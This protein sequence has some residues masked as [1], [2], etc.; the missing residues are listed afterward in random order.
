[1]TLHDALP[2]SPESPDTYDPSDPPLV[3]SPV[4]TDHHPTPTHCGVSLRALYGWLLPSLLPMLAAGT[5][6]LGWRAPAA[7]AT[8]VVSTLVAVSLWRLVGQRGRSLHYTHA[9]LLAGLLA[10]LMPAELF[11]ASNPWYSVG[12]GAAWPLL[13]AAGFTLAFFYWLLGGVGSRL[14]PVA[15]SALALLIL[16][17]TQLSPTNVLVRPHL[18]TGNLLSA[19]ASPHESSADPHLTLVLPENSLDAFRTEPVSSRLTAFM[20]GSPSPDGIWLSLESLLRDRLPP[21]EDLI[22]GGHPG[23]IGLTSTVAVLFAG[24]TLLYRGGADW[25]IPL[26]VL[27]TAFTAF[28]FLRLPVVITSTGPAWRWM[29]FREQGV[30]W[31]TL[32]TFAFYQIAAGPLV[33]TAFFLATDHASAPTNRRGRILYAALLGT[34]AAA[35]QLYFSTQTGPLAAL[36]LLSLL[37]PTLTRVTRPKP[38]LN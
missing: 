15:A 32:A 19:V 13:V 3:P 11:S 12:P 14:H 7:F 36:L 27:I 5:F 37:S 2:E 31:E 26:I 33:F 28:F 35:A 9:T 24:L 6:F 20:R 29:A 25:R 34:S 21:L 8:V 17:P 30:S 4:L 16:F 10:C 38:L 23:T 18:L 22:V 1:M